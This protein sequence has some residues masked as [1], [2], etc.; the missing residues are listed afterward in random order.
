MRLRSVL[1][2]AVVAAVAVFAVPTSAEAAV[3]CGIIMPTK[4]VISAPTV[5]SDMTLTSGCFTNEADHANWD[6]W[7]PGSGFGYA[8][9]FTSADLAEGA[10]WQWAWSDDEPMGRW[11]TEATGAATGDGTPLTQNDAATLVKYHSTFSV[12]GIRRE[13]AKL[14]M[15]STVTQWSGRAHAYVGRPNLPVALQFKAKGST[16][17]T[18]VKATTS[19]S[20]GKVTMTVASPK[21]GSY[22]LLVA[23]TNTVWAAY[24]SA[25]AGR[26]V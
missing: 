21:S 25:V 17:W 12:V 18:Y 13:T 26:N 10:Y 6:V 20:T 9:D 11:T 24:S 19:S 7:H 8:N 14:S 16:T 22:R 15:Y 23:E 5:K 3:Q 4:V 2:P 1:V